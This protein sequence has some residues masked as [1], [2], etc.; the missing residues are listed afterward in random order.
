[1]YDNMSYENV[2]WRQEARIIDVNDAMYEEKTQI[3]MR[4]TRDA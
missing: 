3:A 4:K 2:L 1:M